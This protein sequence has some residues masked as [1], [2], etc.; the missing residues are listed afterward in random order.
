MIKIGSEYLEYEQIPE[1][2]KQVKT[3]DTID[4]AGDFSYSFTVPPTP[5][6]VRLLKVGLNQSDGNLNKKIPCTIERFGTP[7]HIG[8][9][10]V[11]SV[12]RNGIS[13]TF[14]S[15]NTEW[16]TSITDPI[17]L[18]DLSAYKLPLAN[19]V[20]S[21]VVIDSWTATEGII[22]PLVDTG[23]LERSIAKNV[24]DFKPF[25]YVK[26]VMQAI[27]QQNGFKLAG[28]MLTDSVYTKLV[29]GIDNQFDPA[30]DYLQ[31]KNAFIGKT[32]GQSVNTTAS[33]LTFS[34]TSYPYYNTGGYFSTNRYIADVDMSMT[35]SVNLTLDTPDTYI[36]TL[37]RNGS[38]IESY[39]SSGDSI[40]F[41]FND[42]N[43][44]TIDEGEY[45]EVWMETGSGPVNITAGSIT[46]KMIRFDATY[47]Q[48]LLGNMLQSDFVRGIFRMLNVIASYDQFTKTVTCNLFKNVTESETDLSEYISDYEIE[49]NSLNREIGERNRFFFKEGEEERLVE[50]NK[51]NNLPYGA[52]E[53][54]SESEVVG[55]DTEYEL[56][57]ASSFSYYSDTFKTWLTDLGTLYF[58]DTGDPITIT[59]VSNS[60]GDAL[61]TTSADHGLE[62]L[63]FIDITDTSTGEY[64]G[65]GRVS[66]V[67]TTTTFKIQ[68]VDFLAGATG[69]AIKQVRNFN[70]T[71]NVFI[72]LVIPDLA[73]SDFMIDETQ[74]D[75]VG[76]SHSRIAYFYFIKDNLGL[77]I[78]NFREL[79]VFG[80]DVQGAITLLDKFY[81]EQKKFFNKPV[82]LRASMNIPFNVYNNLDQTKSV[83]I[84]TDMFDMKGFAIKNEGYNGPEIEC[85]FEFINLE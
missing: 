51:G 13:L 46:F 62:Q 63:D 75:Y 65:T 39:I 44:V 41:T 14:Y 28:E 17:Y 61:F 58:E 70:S 9:L 76:T 50:Y 45:F 5:V 16:F 66:T 20:P 72:G 60:G 83:R 68:N 43:V 42:G 59:G 37:R 31:L 23:L 82:K 47:P 6:N 52:G 3:Q 29:V 53:I 24:N 26:T 25:V 64:V 80:A 54:I 19:T 18:L 36:I 34:E 49:N 1:V 10:A 67:P 33:L 77:P 57:F 73:V 32:A 81:G 74:I 11:D 38:T 71:G 40:S 84:K 56:P 69:T 2:V 78:D 22:Y 55:E 30:N 8:Y 27:F 48:F 79:P 7:I 12:V 85:F 4:V 35:V 15:G 21:S